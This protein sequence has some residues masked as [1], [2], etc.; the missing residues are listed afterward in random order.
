MLWGG[1]P[2]YYCDNSKMGDPCLSFTDG[3]CLRMLLTNIR[4]RC[5][6]LEDTL[7][8]EGGRRG[9]WGRRCAV[10]AGKIGLLLTGPAFND[11]RHNKRAL[12]PEF[13]EHL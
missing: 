8:G 13:R 1:I 4:S 3:I 12:A 5:P 2:C 10:P 6:Q 7:E 11:T 9:L